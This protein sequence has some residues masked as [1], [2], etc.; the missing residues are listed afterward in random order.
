MPRFPSA[1][2]LRSH[3]LKGV[4]L[5]SALLLLPA[6]GRAEQ[7]TKPAAVP[8]LYGTQAEAEQ[9]ARKHFHCEGAHR[10]GHQWMPCKQHGQPQHQ[11]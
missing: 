7:S 3:R 5:G 9:A 6:A 4:L 8:A 1:T 2:P 10:M 11:H